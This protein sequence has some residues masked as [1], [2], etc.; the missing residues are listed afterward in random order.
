MY[1][2]LINSKPSSCVLL[3]TILCCSFIHLSAQHQID[4]FEIELAN[5]EINIDLTPIS[6][7]E[8]GLIVFRRLLETSIDKYKFTHLDTSLNIV[9]QRD[10]EV[11]KDL[12]LAGSIIKDDILFLLFRSIDFSTANFQIASITVDNG[13]SVVSTVKNVIPFNPAEFVI[14]DEAAFMRG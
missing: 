11:A 1:S 12:V 10:I 13:E 8:K 5:N 9:W 7:A 2:T 14:T 6:A 4:R 3:I